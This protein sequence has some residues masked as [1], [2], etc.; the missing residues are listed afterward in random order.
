MLVVWSL[1]LVVALAVL[2]RAADAFISAAESIGIRLDIPP[3]VVGVTIV[4]VGTTLP[5][6]V[7]SVVAVL[8]DSPQ[9]PL[10]NVVGSIVTNVFLVLGVAAVVGGRLRATHE[11]V[12]VDLPLL[13]GSAL[14]V[15]LV[16]FD[17][18]VT[19]PEAL[20]CLLGAGLYIAYG[21]SAARGREAV[22]E[23]VERR[24]EARQ[25]ETGPARIAVLAVLS[26]TGLYFGAEYTVRAVIELSALLGVGRDVIALSVVALGTSLPELTVGVLSSRRGQLEIAIGNVLGACVLNGFAVVGVAGLV[27]RLEASDVVL[28]LGLPVMVAAALLYFFMA[29]DREITKWEGYLLLLLY[30]LYLIQLAGRV[31]GG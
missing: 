7:S 10:G 12:R 23:P 19:R 3:Y 22:H 21:I 1:V 26:A 30:G 31:T 6:M 13:V 20:V 24:V 9:I 15:A 28:G 17:G 27:G 25:A 16:A 5:E 11:I 29:E 14:V 8:V 4:A 2:I 18:E